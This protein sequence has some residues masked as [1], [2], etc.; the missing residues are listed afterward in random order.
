MTQ[1]DAWFNEIESF[2]TRAERFL[3]EC[4]YDIAMYNRMIPWLKAAYEVGRAELD[5]IKTYE[6]DW[7]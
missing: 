1:F 3:S 5:Q 2:G 7:K 4:N 6:D